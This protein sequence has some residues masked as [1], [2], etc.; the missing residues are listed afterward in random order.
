MTGYFCW[1][2]LWREILNRNCHSCRCFNLFWCDWAWQAS[3]P[4]TFLLIRPVRSACTRELNCGCKTCKSLC[5]DPCTV[6][7][8][9]R[10]RTSTVPCPLKNWQW[11][12]FVLFVKLRAGA[13]SITKLVLVFLPTF[14]SK[15][16]WAKHIS[17]L[18]NIQISWASYSSGVVALLDEGMR[19]RNQWAEMGQEGCSERQQKVC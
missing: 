16:N 7:Y 19:S 12:A 3:S 1:C 9:G 11:G 15:M 4:V 10:S 8:R 13:A 17:Y 14:Q 2:L 6:L 18:S 5:V